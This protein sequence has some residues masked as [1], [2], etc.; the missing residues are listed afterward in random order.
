[1]ISIGNLLVQT[2]LNSIG[3]SYVVISSPVLLLISPSA[4]GMQSKQQ[5]G[6]PFLEAILVPGGQLSLHT[7]TGT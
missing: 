5:T 6:S 1:M 2:E 3:K 7:D 4:H